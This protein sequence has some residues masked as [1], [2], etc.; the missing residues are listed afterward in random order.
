M[1]EGRGWGWEFWRFG[2]CL[3]L[4]HRPGE[5]R[6]P[7]DPL[8]VSPDSS[9]RELKSLLQPL[10]NVL[11]RGQKLICKGKVL[12]D[13]ATLK[14]SQISDGSKVMLVASH[15]VHQGDGPI[16]NH[17]SANLRKNVNVSRTHGQ[18]ASVA[19]EKS[20]LERWRL[21]GIVALS[22]FQLKVIPEEVWACGLQARL[23]DLSN[24]FIAE[25][26]A[27]IGTLAS[28][29]KL[30]L[31]ANNLSD[32]SINWEGISCLKSL[33]ILNLSQNHLT[34]LPSALCTLT[35]L[36]QVDLA[37]NRLTGLPDDIGN[38]N[39]LQVLKTGNNRI[40]SIPSTIGNCSSLIEVDLSSNL[41]DCLPEAF[42]LLTNLKCLQLRNNGL[43]SL[44][45]TLLK[46]CTQLSTLDLHGTQ[47][48]DDVLRQLE[49]WEA[50]DERRRL[51]HQKQLDFR[52][53]VP[54][55]FDEGADKNNGP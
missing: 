50:F 26:P 53:G 21:T 16:T 23:L 27:K 20:R 22:D 49:G 15:G 5:V 7:D 54:Q 18:Q 36:T 38:L 1:E 29:S 6:R 51:K 37:N 43:Q 35:S 14:S 55:G 17:T 44:P 12:A 3:F 34:A 47:I 8:S 31:N 2:F 45:A 33:A 28:I 11:P 4:H 40:R 46:M 13:P 9:V 24:N 32:N 52:L 25:I 19:I 39:Q 42:G 41:L 10:T 30:F 48:T